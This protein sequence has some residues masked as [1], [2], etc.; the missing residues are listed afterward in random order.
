MANNNS[1]TSSSVDDVIV[2]LYRISI[3][4]ITYRL[5]YD[6]R[7]RF[8]HLKV[9]SS[10]RFHVVFVFIIVN[11][12][13]VFTGIKTAYSNLA[14]FNSNLTLIHRTDTDLANNNSDIFCFINNSILNHYVTAVNDIINRFNR[15]FRTSFGNFEV[16]CLA[17]FS[18]VIISRIVNSYYILTRKQLIND[19]TCVIVI[20][21][22]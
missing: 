2:Y 13:Y 10:L 22:T 16:G 15:Y 3:N 18:V 21:F 8:D 17:G 14:V 4:N 12:Y 20:D 5:Y 1:V 19:N 6:F 9:G 7:T 11:A